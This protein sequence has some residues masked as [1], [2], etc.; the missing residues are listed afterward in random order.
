MSR[1]G[2]RPSRFTAT[3]DDVKITYPKEEKN[4]KEENKM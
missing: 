2:V 4:P 1:E 3:K